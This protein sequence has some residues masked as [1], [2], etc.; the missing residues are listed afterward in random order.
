MA[1]LPL[2]FYIFGGGF[3]V[4]KMASFKPNLSIKT[5]G[6]IMNAARLFAVLLLCLE[7]SQGALAEEVTL[8]CGNATASLFN[9]SVKGSP[10]FVLTVQVPIARK[11]YPYLMDREYFEMRCETKSD[12]K[13]VIL[14]NHFCGGSSCVESNYGIIDAETGKQLLEPSAGFR[15]NDDQASRVLGHPVK[16]FSCKTFSKTSARTLGAEGEHCF[17]SSQ[18]LG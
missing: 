1:F 16:P 18:E 9:S 11:Y 10:F 4:G 3:K 13:K 8:R 17:M 2:L 14:L 15:G 12:G 6:H 7:T 5:L